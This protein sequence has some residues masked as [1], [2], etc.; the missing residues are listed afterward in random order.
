MPIDP[1]KKSKWGEIHANVPPE[2][3]VNLTDN[4]VCTDGEDDAGFFTLIACNQFFGEVCCEETKWFGRL[5]KNIRSIMESPQACHEAEGKIVQDERCGA[6]C[7]FKAGDAGYTH[8]PKNEI[9]YL[10]LSAEQCDEFEGDTVADE[11]CHLVCCGG[12]LRKATRTDYER[13]NFFYLD[14]NDNEKPDMIPRDFDEDDDNWN[15]DIEPEDFDSKTS[16]GECKG[17]KIVNDKFVE[18]EGCPAP[19]CP[20][21]KQ[22]PEDGCEDDDVLGPTK[23]DGEQCECIPTECLEV[24]DEGEETGDPRRWNPAKEE[25]DCPDNIVEPALDPEE[26]HTFH[27]TDDGGICCPPE[28]KFDNDTQECIPCKTKTLWVG[29][30]SGDENNNN[31]MTAFEEA[32]SRET[33]TR[34]VTGKLLKI[35]K[36]D[37]WPPDWQNRDAYLMGPHTVPTSPAPRPCPSLDTLVQAAT[38][39]VSSMANFV[40]DGEAEIIIY[41]A[42]DDSGSVPDGTFSDAGVNATSLEN[43]VME[44]LNDTPCCEPHDDDGNNPCVSVN[45]VLIQNAANE[46]FEA[47]AFGAF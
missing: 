8:V 31:E 46:N 19:H 43:A 4:Y 3:L 26:E 18:L 12:P 15:I 20:P 47:H 33:E 10:Y 25:C 24:D 36:R 28:K 35:G 14:E 2:E 11:D 29:I 39:A 32:K 30:A 27:D 9:M 42:L 22:K 38:S 1:E 41:F 6:C 44:K 16:R 45:M 23:W 5:R 21:E 7:K 17:S 40:S 37:D 34:K 13:E